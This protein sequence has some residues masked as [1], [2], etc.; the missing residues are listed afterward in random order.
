MV[1]DVGTTLDSFGWVGEEDMVGTGLGL[2]ER[3]RSGL[4]PVVMRLKMEN[5]VDVVAGGG[6]DDGEDDDTV[7]RCSECF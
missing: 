4:F 7:V 5:A 2:G 3:F 1:D 6:G